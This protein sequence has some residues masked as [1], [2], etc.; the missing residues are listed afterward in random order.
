MG[1]VTAQATRVFDHRTGRVTARPQ[2]G[3]KQ[4]VETGRPGLAVLSVIAFMLI[5]VFPS[6][7]LAVE[8]KDIVLSESGIHYPGGFDVNTV[9]DVQGNASGIHVSERGPVR[10]QVSTGR[11]TFTVLASPP[12]Y[13]QDIGGNTI[14]GKRVQVRGS[15]TLGKDGN[16][17]IIAQDVRIIDSGKI[18]TFR[19]E[20]G[21]P[22]WRGGQMGGRGGFGSPMRG[23]GAGRGAGAGGRGRR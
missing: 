21:F 15:K 14:E 3:R 4:S 20:S 16:L 19:D 6:M 8:E 17:Y 2:I 10:F 18:L 5:L 7:T 1:R 23:D 9:G 11:D 22:H 13:W 12:W